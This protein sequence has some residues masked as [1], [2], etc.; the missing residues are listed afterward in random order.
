M[1][2]TF[3]NYLSK[4]LLRHMDFQNCCIHYDVINYYNAMFLFCNE[5]QSLLFAYRQSEQ[6][7][8]ALL[9]IKIENC[10]SPI[11]TLHPIHLLVLHIFQNVQRWATPNYNFRF[12]QI[13]DR[14]AN[15][16]SKMKGQLLKQTIP[17][18]N[19]STFNIFA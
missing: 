2:L 6:S 5:L 12:T 3:A 18:N 14:N 13:G 15:S 11:F 19:D 10:I 8:L 17:G 16:H 7:G 1:Q 4:F 9:V